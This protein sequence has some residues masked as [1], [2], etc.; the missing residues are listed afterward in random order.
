M[1]RNRILR[2]GLL[3]VG[4]LMALGLL[5]AAPAEAAVVRHTVTTVRTTHRWPMR[6][7]RRHHNRVMRHIAHHPLRDRDHDGV[8]NV[9]DRHPM[10]NHR[11]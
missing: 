1:L 10:N 7:H 4:A 5:G 3:G 11:R 2:A 6:R 8:P 9:V